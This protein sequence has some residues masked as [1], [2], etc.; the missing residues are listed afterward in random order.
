MDYEHAVRVNFGRPMPVFPL[1]TAVVVPQQVVPL[2]IF[3]DRY[4]RMVRDVLDGSGQ[5]AMAVFAGDDWKTGY[6]GRPALRP[7]VCI[8]QIMQHETLP[9]GRFDI[10]LQ[11]ICRAKIVE[12]AEPSEGQLYR[13]VLLQPIGVGDVDEEELED[14]RDWLDEALS[15]SPLTQMTRAEEILGYVRKPEIPTSALLELVSFSMTPNGELRYRL[16]A[17]GDAG[18]RAR[19][20][21]DELEHVQGLIRQARAQHPEEW[22]KGCSWN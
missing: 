5:I 1:S 17:E 6:T 8:G 19:L 21:R 18:R 10:L 12:E 4:I 13:H 22:P 7:A 11:G 3:E 9:G 15:E 2:H 20:V 14:L 16:L